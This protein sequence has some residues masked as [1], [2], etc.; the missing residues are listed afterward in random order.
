MV[1]CRENQKRR[2]RT[3]SKNKDP[4]RGQ[5]QKLANKWRQIKPL[6]SS[7][8]WLINDAS[9]PARSRE[10]QN[11]T[12]IHHE[13]LRILT[14]NIQAGLNSQAY[15]DY[16][17]A[18]LRQFLPS[19]PNW[20][21]MGAIGDLIKPYDLIAL[22][23][24]D[25]GSH[26][27][28]QLNQL[29]Y[30]AKHGAFEFWHQQLNRNLGRF[31]QFSNGLLSRFTPYQVEDHKL[32]GLPGRGAIIARYKLKDTTITVCCVHLA[33]SEKARHKQLAYIRDLLASEEHLVLMGDMNCLGHNLNSTPISELQLVKPARNLHSYPSWEPTKN[34]DHILVSP[35]LKIS[36]MEVIPSQLSDHCPVAM[37]V[38]VPEKER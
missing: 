20:P 14:F 30:L 12:I 24:L 8:S 27:S 28:G 18:S 26:R 15:S 4:F 21:H 37:T 2:N 19:E 36:Q 1:L 16:V 17:K 38:D 13:S 34:I 35:S 3:L 31:G 5:H 23:E 7:G 33:L 29:S 32:P 25:G 11:P 9:G 10:I 6:I 22:Q